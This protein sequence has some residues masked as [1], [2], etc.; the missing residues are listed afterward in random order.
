MTVPAA[1][2]LLG[3]GLLDVIW[4]KLLRGY[5]SV[6]LLALPGA[7]LMICSRESPKEDELLRLPGKEGT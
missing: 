7:T 3:R 4:I 6:R 5:S 1:A 2:W